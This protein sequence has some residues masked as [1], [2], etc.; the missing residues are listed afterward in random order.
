MPLVLHLYLAKLTVDLAVEQFSYLE[1]SIAMWL[2]EWE[3]RLL[4]DSI[5]QRVGGDGSTLGMDT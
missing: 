4:S 1:K 2:I 3:S 5:I